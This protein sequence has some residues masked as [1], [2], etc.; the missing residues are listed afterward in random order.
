[1]KSRYADLEDSLQDEPPLEHEP[2]AEI[3]PIDEP[4]GPTFLTGVKNSARYTNKHSKTVARR[5][6]RP[7]GVEPESNALKM[8]AELAPTGI[9]MQ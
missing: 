4:E 7:P 3:D 5:L 1:M 8:E 6:R 9:S 2:H